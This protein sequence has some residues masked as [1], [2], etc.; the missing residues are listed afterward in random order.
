MHL[1]ESVPLLEAE[2]VRSTDWLAMV[3]SFARI[4]EKDRGNQAL[5]AMVRDGVPEEHK[6]DVRRLRDLLNR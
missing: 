2:L 6:A 5:E 4:G 1:H 3:E